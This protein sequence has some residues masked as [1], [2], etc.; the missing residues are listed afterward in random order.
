M[1]ILSLAEQRK[2]EKK[3]FRRCKRTEDRVSLTRSMKSNEQNKCLIFGECRVFG[4]FIMENLARPD[5]S[6]GGGFLRPA[7]AGLGMTLALAKFC[8]WRVVPGTKTIKGADSLELK[9]TICR[10]FLQISASLIIFFYPLT[11][12]FEF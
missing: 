8:I 9:P 4:S 2:K 11:D 3:K 7:E 6:L 12:F 10:Q 1:N 5:L